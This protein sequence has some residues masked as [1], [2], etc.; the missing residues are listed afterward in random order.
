MD[1]VVRFPIEQADYV[2]AG[3]ESSVV[4]ELMLEDALV[5]IAAYSDVQ[6]AGQASHD[7]D[8]VV[9]PIAH[10]GMIGEVGQGGCDGCHV[11]RKCLP[12]SGWR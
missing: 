10:E 6:S 8:A 9:A 1:V 5:K 11:G 7:V 12:Y 4:M 2:V 3:G